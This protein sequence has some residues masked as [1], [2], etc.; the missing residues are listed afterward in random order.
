MGLLEKF[1]GEERDLLVALP[2]RVGLW[3]SR[4][5]DTGGAESGDAEINALRGII[6]GFAEDFLKSE[7]VEELMRETVSRKDL[8]PAWE[9]DTDTVPAECTKA[10]GIVAARLEQK[11]TTS[12]KHNLMEIAM[13]VALAY[14]EFDDDQ[15]L[16]EKIKVYFRYYRQRI[17]AMLQNKQILSFD[18]YL[19]I[20]RAEHEALTQLSAALRMEYKE[21]QMPQAPMAAA[22]G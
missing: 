21:G 15:P 14:R 22:E 4:S 1:S 17:E 5:D 6:T 7:F 10:V 13:T 8:W 18:E 12:F 11:S 9:K 19:N 3:L 20:S 16:V 2:Y